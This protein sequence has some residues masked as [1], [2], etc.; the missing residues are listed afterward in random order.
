MTGRTHDAIAFASLITIAAIN[1]P[2]SINIAT[3]TA[4]VVGNII[5]ATLPDIDQSTNRLW[6]FLPGRD[7]VGKLLRPLFLGHRN[8]THSF[9]GM[10][11]VYKILEFI[12][13]RVL[14]PAYVQSGI[15]FAAM[16][17][18][19]ISHLVGDAIT[20]DGLPLLFP[21]PRRFGFPPISALRITTG[22]WVEN[23]IILPGTAAYIF[24]FIGNHHGDFVKLL[25]IISE[26]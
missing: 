10:F 24:W 9:L 18:G 16:I 14:N 13:P 3:A 22:K 17:I 26:G 23:I 8:L 20:K 1:P 19:Y 21:S 4:A 11:L 15:V 7:Y 5:G 6:D 25:K 12:L 2:E